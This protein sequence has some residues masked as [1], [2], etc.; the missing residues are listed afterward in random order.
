[1]EINLFDGLELCSEKHFTP[2][3]TIETIFR[4]ISFNDDD[5]ILEPTAGRELRMFNQIPCD[6]KDFYEIDFGKCFLTSNITKRYTK[7]ITNP[8]YRTNH[9]DRTKGSNIAIKVIEKSFEVCD[10]E[11]WMLLNNQ[12]LNSLTVRRLKK[13]RD[14]Y[15][16]NIVFIR[17]LEIP[18]FYGRYYWICFKKGGKSILHF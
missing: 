14:N 12:M 3:E 5:I 13:Y 9:I 10:D 4:D 8:P 1:M 6:D 15:D 11:V 2:N 7:V 16:F 17:V 18:C